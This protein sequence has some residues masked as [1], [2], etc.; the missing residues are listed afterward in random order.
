MSDICCVWYH[1]GLVT[2][3]SMKASYILL[4]LAIVAIGVGAAFAVTR[5]ATTDTP[6]PVFEEL[7]VIP[8]DERA[9]SPTSGDAPRDAEGV[10]ETPS[11][12]RESEESD[13]NDEIRDNEQEDDDNSNKGSGGSSQP[14]PPAPNA[15][16]VQAQTPAVK[17]FTFAEVATHAS[18]TSCW[19]VVRGEVYDV[20]TWIAQH[21]GGEKSILSMCG[22]DGTKGFEGQHGGDARPE[23][24]LEEF[25]IGVL[26]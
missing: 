20:T 26:Q 2:I 4:G 14:I 13:E 6:T 17:T 16:P 25:K 19:T 18:E 22:K 21:P 5:M 1:I 12:V 24:Q 10:Q 7:A 23:A 15:T 8:T 3:Y 11:D 9:T